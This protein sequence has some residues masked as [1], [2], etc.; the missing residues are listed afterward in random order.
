MKKNISAFLLITLFVFLLNGCGIGAIGSM[1]V[2]RGNHTMPAYTV[3]KKNQ[4]MLEKIATEGYVVK[5]GEFK[6]TNEENQTIKCRMMTSVKPPKDKNY[7]EYIRH[8]FETEFKPSKLLQTHSKV[9]ISATIKEINGRSMY[10]DAYWSFKITLISSNGNSYDVES[11][12]TYDSS[13]RASSACKDM[14]K[15]FPLALQKLIHDAIANPKFKTLLY[16]GTSKK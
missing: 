5:L 9:S 7:K 11:K 13:F 3:S 14:H 12:Y 15:T 6:N 4:T 1:V 2:N 10:G 16:R 8:A